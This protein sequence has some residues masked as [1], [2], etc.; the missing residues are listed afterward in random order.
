MPKR[1]LYN[2]FKPSHYE[3]TLAFEKRHYEKKLPPKQILE[4]NVDLTWSSD[5]PSDMS[6]SMEYLET[7]CFGVRKPLKAV[8]TDDIIIINA[9]GSKSKIA[10]GYQSGQKFG[11]IQER[12]LADGV[13][14]VREPTVIDEWRLLSPDKLAALMAMDGLNKGHKIVKLN[15]CFSA[16]SGTK[17]NV[18]P[19]NSFAAQLAKELGNLRFNRILVGGYPGAHG[20]R[21]FGNDKTG[22]LSDATGTEIGPS[23][24]TRIW[25]GPDGAE[26]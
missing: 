13:R 2:P 1:W 19:D 23:R 25:F 26:V 24:G 3:E 20:R 4:S 12:V 10:V 11:A 17:D 14:T 8:A 22:R 7:G 6:P 21:R 15:S 5:D 9:H 16:G 18:A